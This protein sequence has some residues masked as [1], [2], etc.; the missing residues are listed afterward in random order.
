LG[1]FSCGFK[2]LHYIKHVKAGI[3]G[4]FLLEYLEAMYKLPI[5]ETKLD[6]QFL[7][8]SIRKEVT[9]TQI[10]MGELIKEWLVD[11]SNFKIRSKG[12]YPINNL[13]ASLMTL[14]TMSC[15]LYGEPNAL[16][17]K[18]EWV[19]LIHHVLDKGN[20]FNWVVI[21]SRNLKRQVEKLF[22]SPPGFTPQF[23]MSDYL[24]E[25]VCDKTPFPLLKWS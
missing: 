8:A 19:F 4:Y 18:L 17:F 14:A 20:I 15:R 3:V 11:E 23:F 25:V 1:Y 2:H 9:G 10:H 22:S 21:L 24:I 12:F 7:D 5:P 13:E 16:H 6:S